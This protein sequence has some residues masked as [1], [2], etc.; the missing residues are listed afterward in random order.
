R[1]EGEQK[2]ADLGSP[3]KS[4]AVM[5]LATYHGKL[6]AGTGKYRLVGSALP[7]SENLN[8]GGRVFRLESDG[9][10]TLVGQLPG[11][12]TLASLVVYQDR[13]FASSL[14]RPPG[15]FRYEKDGEWT[16][17]STPAGNRI[18]PLAVFDGY[19]WAGEY[20]KGHVFRFDGKDWQDWGQLGDNT[21]TYSFAIERGQLCVGTWKSG[22][23]FRLEERNRWAD[24][25]RLGEELEVMGMLFYNGKLYAGSLPLAEL[26]R[27]DGDNAW[28]SVG[29]L[30]LTPDVKY[31]RIWTCAQYQGRLVATALPSGHVHALEAGACVT[32][33]H[34]LP[35]GWQHV[36]GV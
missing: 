6:Y 14:Y 23:V 29:R 5:S 12:E 34:E 13:L 25:G 28:R 4:N 19:L 36:A 27:H 11:V 30:D 24:T 1:Y 10:W 7:E 3:D 17:L 2:W 8:L 16:S 31:R 21:Q 35:A 22:R 26:Y 20:D 33:D 32:H 15:F 9:R 18:E